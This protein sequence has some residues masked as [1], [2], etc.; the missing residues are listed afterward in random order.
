MKSPWNESWSCVAHSSPAPEAN[1]GRDD[2][3]WLRRY[4][5]A[6]LHSRKTVSPY[7]ALSVRILHPGRLRK[8]IIH[9]HIIG[10]SKLSMSSLFDFQHGDVVS[11]V[12]AGNDRAWLDHLIS[13]N[14]IVT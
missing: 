8:H 11:G 5:T 9:T 10:Y 12:E 2:P 7:A 13:Q 3:S 14:L 1:N 4:R 6:G